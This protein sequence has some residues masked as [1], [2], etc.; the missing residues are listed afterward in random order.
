MDFEWDEI[1]HV[2]KVD[3][4]KPMPAD[5]TILAGT[6]LVLVGGS[7]TVSEANTLAAIEAVRQH[8]P[9]VPVAQ[10]PYDGEHVSSK[11]IAATDW[12]AIPAVYNG[13][14]D[15]F[16][17][18]HLDVFATIASAPARSRGVNVPLFGKYLESKGTAAV[19]ELARSIVGEGY[20]IQHLDSAAARTAGV[21]RALSADEV[22]GAA[23]AT[24]HYYGF[25][26]F[27]V[28]YSGT[29]GGPADI[30]AAATFLEETVLLYG[31]GIDSREKADEILAA[32]ADAIVVGDC[33]HED[34]A[35][36]E[37]TIPP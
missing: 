19:G 14:R 28:E 8:A 7:D 18:K 26:I 23:M 32:G 17:G 24:E 29:Y 35:A 15:H 25:P 6:D 2:T 34:P 4:A 31:G 3:P 5:P 27:Y 10:E 20:V 21:E 37:R 11:T 22:A 12:L 30:E 1:S 16:V 36:F 33:F 13:N 9:D